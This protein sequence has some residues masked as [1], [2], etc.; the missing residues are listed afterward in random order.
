MREIKFRYRLLHLDSK[1]IETAFLTLKELE[2]GTLPY[3]YNLVAFKVLTRDEFTGLL[4]KNGKEIYEGDIL[5]A[6]N[7]C[8]VKWNEEKLAW[9]NDSKV[10]KFNMSNKGIYE[11]IGNIYEN[12]E[13]L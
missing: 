3:L 10:W 5:K 4:D 9:T 13:L 12:P 1:Q 11:V 8:V 2:Q 6:T 7:P